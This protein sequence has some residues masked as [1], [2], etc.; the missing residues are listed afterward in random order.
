[1]LSI[2]YFAID[3]G[4]SS[5]NKT[6]FISFFLILEIKRRGPLPAPHPPVALEEPNFISGG[7]KR[8]EGL[9]SCGVL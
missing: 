7:R 2:Y 1:M 3:K 6:I 9:V 8:R 5:L 4:V